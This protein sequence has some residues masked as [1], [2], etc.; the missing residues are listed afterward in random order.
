MIYVKPPL[1]CDIRQHIS[2]YR[3]N[4][5]ITYSNEHDV[6]YL[7]STELKMSICIT[8]IRGGYGNDKDN[9]RCLR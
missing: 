2:I 9:L 5:K 4:F 6:I 3:S 8:C 7:P 1:K